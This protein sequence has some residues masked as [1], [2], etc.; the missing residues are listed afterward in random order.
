MSTADAT[1][2]FS[3]LVVCSKQI[4]F[5]YCTKNKAY[6]FSPGSLLFDKLGEVIYA[7][8]LGRAEFVFVMRKIL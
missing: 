1:Q 8:L 6:L 2:Q 7:G 4:P 5:L 3:V